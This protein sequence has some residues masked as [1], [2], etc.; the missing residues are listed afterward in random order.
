MAGY[1]TVG[2]TVETELE[3]QRSRFLSVAVHVPDEEGAKDAIAQRRTQYPDASHHCYGYTIGANMNPQRFSDDGEPGGTAGMPILEVIKAQALTFTVVIVTRYFGGILL[4]ANGLVRAYRAGAIQ[5]LQAA[6][7]VCMLP[8][9]VVWA[10][11]PYDLWDKVSYHMRTCPYRMLDTEYG[12]SVV[13]K[14]MVKQSDEERLEY[15]FAQW[16][17][18]KALLLLD[19][20]CDAPWEE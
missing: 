4:G 1:F 11:V 2:Q 10:D 5:A 12:S 8:S 19:E 18:G 15:D 17:D 14:L 7:R 3:I 13:I 9:R 6:G 20:P 16:T